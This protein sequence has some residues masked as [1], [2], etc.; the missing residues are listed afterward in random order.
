MVAE[1]AADAVTR[2]EERLQIVVCRKVEDAATASKKFTLKPGEVIKLG[3]HASNELA[4]NYEGVSKHH[5]EI[6]LKPADQSESKD[7]GLSALLSIRDGGS[8]NG[9]SIRKPSVAEDGSA[10]VS[11]EGWERVES[12]SSMP[13]KTGYEVLL[14]AKSRQG[15][16]Q[17]RT[18]VRTLTVEVSSVFVDVPVSAPVVK[19]PQ[20]APILQG[21]GTFQRKPLNAYSWRPPAAAAAPPPAAAV[22][23][24][25]PVVSPQVTPERPT[26]RA[27]RPKKKA[28]P[29][30]DDVAED[31]DPAGQDIA[32]PQPS[33]TT[34]AIPG[35]G[36][37]PL[38]SP[39]PQRRQKPS[40]SNII[41]GPPPGSVEVL[42]DEEGRAPKRKSLGARLTEANVRAAS[43]AAAAAVGLE[44][45]AAP[46]DDLRS[47]S[48]ISTPGVFAFAQPTKKGG[49]K[50]PK[51][52]GDSGSEGGHRR[53]K[54]KIGEGTSGRSGKVAKR[55]LL[56]A[57]PDYS[58][59]ARSDPYYAR[60]ESPMSVRGGHPGS[61]QDYDRHHDGRKHR[62][63]GEKGKKRSK[64]KD[65]DRSRR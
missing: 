38:T 53:K 29:L 18:D 55:T 56:T 33:H 10:Q 42:S 62:D 15:N 28:A 48:P 1:G 32:P 26:A 13:L 24:S 58:A 22:P 3:R 12:G 7:G 35:P 59:P 54:R 5:A 34:A 20:K 46:E 60:G 37:R 31:M 41:P 6:F 47:I 27:A 25:P 8:R 23:V 50:K 65:G 2:Q 4:L 64:H 19:S 36:Q 21:P 30:V 43:A 40:A 9:T 63:R 57:A 14:P 17:I 51:G 49:K 39:V 11:F 16:C 44:E 61:S 52:A 45:P